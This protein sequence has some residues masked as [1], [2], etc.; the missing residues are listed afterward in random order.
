MMYDESPEQRLARVE[1][2]RQHYQNDTYEM[3]DDLDQR[4]LAKLQSISYRELLPC[5]RDVL[6][7]LLDNQNDAACQNLRTGTELQEVRKQEVSAFCEMLDGNNEIKYLSVSNAIGG[8]RRR[9]EGRRIAAI[10]VGTV[11]VL[12]MAWMWRGG[13]W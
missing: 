10:A 5:Q 7:L 4:M 6:K 9:T 3:P 2:L 11:L 12:A 8:G 13:N 1:V